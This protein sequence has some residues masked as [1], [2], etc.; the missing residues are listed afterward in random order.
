MKSSVK[1]L[2]VCQNMMSHQESAN[3]LGWGNDLGSS[4][5]GGKQFHADFGI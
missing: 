3:A 2:K 4:N 5:K 1:C